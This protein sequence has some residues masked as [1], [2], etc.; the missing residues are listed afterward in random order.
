MVPCCSHRPFSTSNASKTGLCQK[1]LLRGKV[2]PRLGQVSSKL[3]KVRSYRALTKTQNDTAL[4]ERSEWKADY[5]VG[6]DFRTTRK[7]HTFY[8]LQKLGY[9]IPPPC[10][11]LNRKGGVPT[12]LFRVPVSTTTTYCVV[13]ER[14][15]YLSVSS[16]RSYVESVAPPTHCLEASIV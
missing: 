12:L 16:A 15:T 9:S 4:L 2:K 5:V 1:R 7:Y 10:L 3:H 6:W 8:R 14:M 11:G 13:K